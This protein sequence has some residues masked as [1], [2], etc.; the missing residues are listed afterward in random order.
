MNK[1]SKN[2]KEFSFPPEEE[3]QRVIKRFTDPN[4]TE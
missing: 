4:I 3:M 2:R 1:L